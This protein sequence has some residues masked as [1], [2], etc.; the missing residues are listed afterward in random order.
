MQSFVAVPTTHRIAAAPP[1]VWPSLTPA[2]PDRGR[3]TDDAEARR[4]A[5]VELACRRHGG[6][7]SAV[8]VVNMLSQC[9]HAQ[10]LSRVAR[11]LVA[12]DVVSFEWQARAWLP[13]FQFEL[14]AMSVR[15]EVT[16]VIRE[17]S[18]V[19]DEWD[20]VSWFTSPNT[21]L[22]NMTPVAAM[23]SLP[24]AVMEAARADRFIARG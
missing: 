21:W 1:A 14:S 19:F 17:L 16:A 6:M 8:E 3:F 20:L 22:A 24:A 5:A 7:A 12:G 4:M 13:L 11:W 23:T 2:P 10:P 9:N 15:P 18:S